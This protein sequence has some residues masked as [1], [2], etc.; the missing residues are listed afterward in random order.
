MRLS[1]EYEEEFLRLERTAGLDSIVFRNSFAG[2]S[3]ARKASPCKAGWSHTACQRQS[4][5][6]PSHRATDISA[7]PLSALTIYYERRVHFDTI[8]AEKLLGNGDLL[9]RA[10]MPMP[11]RVQAPLLLAEEAEK[12]LAE[13]KAV[14]NR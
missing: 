4:L 8:G 6:A 14:Y 2:L 13:M 1:S 5:C 10:N 3:G 12:I 9:F 11:V 7:T